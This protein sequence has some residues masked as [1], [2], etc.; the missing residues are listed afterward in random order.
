[1]RRF[2]DRRDAG[3]RLADELK[4]FH[5]LADAVVLALPRG[6]VPVAFEVAR[7]LGAP[8][9]VL[10]VRKLGLPGHEELAM[11]A[12]SSGGAKVLNDHIVRAYRIEPSVID[13]VAARETEELRRREQAYRSGRPMLDVRGRTA[14]VVDDGLATG[15][16]MRAAVR[17]LR[18]MS[19]ARIIVAVPVGSVETCASLQ[20][21]ADEVVC[22]L[23]PEDLYAVGAWYDDF[24]QTS[25]DEVRRLL[26]LTPAGPRP[27][28]AKGAKHQGQ[29]GH[30]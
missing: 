17:A 19:P 23:Q 21:E 14:L 6:G 5:D 20:D 12:I 26:D 11:G 28:A 3:K 29:A 8:M 10:V 15:A 4:E 9:D 27:G 18:T 24:T 25:D 16:T 7:A 22:A 13:Q 2:Q 30:A 1:M